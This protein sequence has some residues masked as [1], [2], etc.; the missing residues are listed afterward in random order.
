MH[1]HILQTWSRRRRALA[2]GA[3]N[4]VQ[5]NGKRNLLSQNWSKNDA[6]KNRLHDFYDIFDSHV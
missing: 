6:K 1:P 2:I 4:L 3:D 5:N